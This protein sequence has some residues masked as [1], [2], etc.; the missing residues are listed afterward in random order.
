MLIEGFQEQ[1]M[2]CGKLQKR[3]GTELMTVTL[4][5]YIS[6]SQRGAYAPQG[7]NL[8]VGGGQ[9]ANR[10]DTYLTQGCGVGLKIFDSDSDSD[11]GLFNFTTPTPTYAYYVIIT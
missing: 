1:C 8:V 9:L 6:V 7:G 4:T 11:F 10:P 3:S 2:T 5:I